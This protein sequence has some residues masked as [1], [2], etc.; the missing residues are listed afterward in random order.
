M[1]RHQ[2]VVVLLAA[3][4]L[5]TIVVYN[6]F[7]INDSGVATRPIAD[8]DAYQDLLLN[9]ITRIQGELKGRSSYLSVIGV[10]TPMIGLTGTNARAPW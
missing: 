6:K 8:M 2:R 3:N 5:P 1:G 10:C 7:Y 4:D 9:K